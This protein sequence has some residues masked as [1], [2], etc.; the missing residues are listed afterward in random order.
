ME[1]EEGRALARKEELRL[2]RRPKLIKAGIAAVILL[3][4]LWY[5]RRHVTEPLDKKWSEFEVEVEKTREPAHWLKDK[6][7]IQQVVIRG[8]P[9]PFSPYMSEPYLASGAPQPSRPP[10]F[11]P[12]IPPREP[13]PAV[14]APVPAT[15]DMPTLRS[16]YGVVYDLITLQPLPSARIIIKENDRTVTTTTTDL[17]GHYHLVMYRGP[18]NGQMSVTVENPPGYREGVLEDRDPPL[19]ERSP[20][21]RKAVFDETTDNDLEPVPMRC[22]DSAQNVQLDLVLLPAVKN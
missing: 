11:K 9:A 12:A 1:L 5:N 17:E 21:D 22:P 18:S 16:W 20:V 7:P 8:A 14:A 4:A 13:S 3:C 19:R 10:D 2:E 6:Q 15:P